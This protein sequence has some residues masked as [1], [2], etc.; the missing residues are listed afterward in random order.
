[1]LALCKLERE[2]LE[3]TSSQH[4]TLTKSG[5]DICRSSSSL[6]DFPNFVRGEVG[7]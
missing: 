3:K 6:F 4:A 5:A 2:I 1:M 7:M